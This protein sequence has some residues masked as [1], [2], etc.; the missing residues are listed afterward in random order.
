MR[1][2]MLNV[3]G[4]CEISFLFHTSE[5]NGMQACRHTEDHSKKGKAESQPTM[6]RINMGSR[7]RCRPF[8][9]ELLHRDEDEDQVRNVNTNR[10]LSS[11]HCQCNLDEARMPSRQG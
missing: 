6:W 9:Q 8:L 7:I 10:Y 5:S 2:K 4:P 3:L 1:D 11:T